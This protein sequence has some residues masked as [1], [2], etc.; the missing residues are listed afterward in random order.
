MGEKKM[1]VNLSGFLVVVFAALFLVGLASG[2]ENAGPEDLEEMSDKELIEKLKE[3]PGLLE[4]EEVSEEF[5]SRIDKDVNL[6]NNNPEILKNWLGKYDIKTEKNSLANVEIGENVTSIV[7]SGNNSVTFEADAVSEATIQKDGS[8]KLSDGTIV[9]NSYIGTEEG[10]FRAKGGEVEVSEDTSR[11]INFDN[12]EVKYKGRKFG[13]ASG[14]GTFRVNNGVASVN[15]ENVYVKNPETGKRVSSI[16]GQAT[17]EGQGNVNLGENTQYR[18]LN[19]EG[20]IAKE[21]SVEKPTSY[22]RSGDCKSENCIKENSEGVIDVSVGKENNI[23]FKGDESVESFNVGNIEDRSSVEFEDAEGNEVYFGKNRFLIRDGSI[24]GLEND[25]EWN[26][27]NA[28]GE[29]RRYRFSDDLDMS[30]AMNERVGIHYND[31]GARKENQ[32]LG[33]SDV[34]EDSSS[35]EESQERTNINK[36]DGDKGSNLI[37]KYN[38]LQNL[39]QISKSDSQGKEIDY[40]RTFATSLKAYKPDN[41][42]NIETTSPDGGTLTEKSRTFDV[43]YPHG[44]KPVGAAKAIRQAAEWAS[45][46]VIDEN[47]QVTSSS[48]DEYRSKFEEGIITDSNARIKSY[49]LTDSGKLEVSDSQRLKSNEPCKD[50]DL[51]WGRYEVKVSIPN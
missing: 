1:K 33:Y 30:Y 38:A 20:E 12:A 47:E 43:K 3:N 6:L 27:K 45:S 23:K 26:Y 14:M 28:D 34:L 35:G 19:E 11:D 4:D 37:V 7:T 42:S 5:N 8:L 25:I 29:D 22:L 16:S 44:A 10:V 36:L 13:S 41:S 40:R 49:R 46:V 31:D 17:F 32:V 24:F 39:R 21:V 2:I 48:G 51:C 50:G 9:K 15:G 18:T